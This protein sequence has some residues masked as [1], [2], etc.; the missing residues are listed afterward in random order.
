MAY[1]PN[2]NPYI[3]GDPYSYDLKWIVTQIKAHSEALANLDTRIAA[4]VMAALDQHDPIYF[5]NADALIYSGIK[6]P[7]LAYI[8]GYYT[9]GDG[10]ANLYIT[11]SD[12]NDII[13]APF[14]ITLDGANRWALPII[15]TPYV[16]PEM[17]GAKGDGTTDDSAAFTQALKNAVVYLGAKTY[18]VNSANISASA[19]IIKGAGTLATIIST[20]ASAFTV[21]N[22]NFDLTISNLRING[23]GAGS[24]IVGRFYNFK[25]NSVR[26]SGFAKGLEITTSSW[27]GFNK[28]GDVFI[29]YCTIGIDVATSTGFNN[30]SFDNC[31]FQH[32]TTGFKGYNINALSFINCDFEGNTTALNIST[33]DALTIT[34]AY[35]E[36]NTKFIEIVDAF[37]NS[38]ITVKES[39]I[40]RPNSSSSGWLA[41]LGTY[42]SANNPRGVVAFYDNVIANYT[43]ADTPAFAFNNNGTTSYIY[44]NLKNNHFSSIT[45]GAPFVYTD[46]FDLTNFNAYATYSVPVPIDS[47]IPFYN[48]DGIII[49]RSNY[50]NSV[51]ANAANVKYHIKALYE[52]TSTGASSYVIN[53]NNRLTP[54][55]GGAAPAMVRYSDLSTTAVRC[56]LASG[57]ITVQNLDSAKTTNFVLLDAD[58]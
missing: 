23:S 28:F 37:Y 8:E 34:S 47:D 41:T 46:L 51:S 1:T 27:S 12:Y 11:T 7:A 43:I 39:Y 30:N 29:D 52:F 35:I 44:V 50:G 13:S 54:N 18:K 9:A 20:D 40:R 49:T 10:G 57:N 56:L 48:Q 33:S 58:Y 19:K 24:A 55:S 38:N 2:N 26:I 4:A 17:F 31:A 25:I 16:T 21:D 14:Y 53:L 36:E 3:A 32:C 45:A 42:S 22:N 6:T 15:L 5:E